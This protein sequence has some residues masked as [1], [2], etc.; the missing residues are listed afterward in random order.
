MHPPKL[1]SRVAWRPGPGGPEA[2]QEGREDMTDSIKGMVARLG[3]WVVKVVPME[4]ADGASGVV[5]ITTMAAVATVVDLGKGEAEVEAG[6]VA[7]MVATEDME[8]GAMGRAATLG[9]AGVVVVASGAGEEALHGAGPN[10][11]LSHPTTTTDFGWAMAHS[12]NVKDSRLL[13]QK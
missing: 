2:H 13:K 8:E 12:G 3:Q 7:T 10:L 4:V 6:P 11:N 1:L 5:D 9:V